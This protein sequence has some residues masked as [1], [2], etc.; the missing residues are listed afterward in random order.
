MDNSDLAS[1]LEPMQ[2]YVLLYNPNTENEGI[3]SLE[4]AAPDGSKQNVILLFES[5][6]DATR[7]AML[8]EA[9]D[10]MAPS[11]E[12]IEDDEVKEF[13]EESGFTWKMIPDGFVPQSEVDRVFLSP[14]ERNLDRTTW[15][16]EGERPAAAAD[17][18]ESAESSDRSTMS[19]A[20]LDRIRRQLEGL[21]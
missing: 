3:H 14:P 1:L 17:K 20:E 21:L 12:P 5:E 8:L 7:Y 6:D 4:L 2:V 15:T 16:T 10:F 9:Q 11:V 18:S 19:Q 13:C